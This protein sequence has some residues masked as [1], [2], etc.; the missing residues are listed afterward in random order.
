VSNVIRSVDPGSPAERAHISV[1]DILLSINGHEIRDVL[2]YKYYSYDAKLTI[3]LLS[4]GKKKRV[5]VRKPESADMGLEFETYLMD[6]ARSCANKCVF[7]FVDQLPR[8]MRDTLYFKDDDHRLSFLQGNYIT[9]TNLSEREIRRIIELKISPINISVHATEPELRAMLLGNKNGGRGIEIMR[10]FA[11]AGITMNCQIVCC[12]GLNDGEH[13][14]KSMADLA[15]MYPGVSSVSVVPVG[16]T[17]HREGLYPLCPFDE[18]LAA[19]TVAL[20][21]GFG[22]KC[23]AQYGTRMFFCADELYLKAHLPLPEDEYYEDY[24]QLENGVGMLRMLICEFRAALRDMPDEPDGN[25]F[26]I[27]CGRSAAPFMEMLINEAAEKYGNVRGVVHAVDNDFFGHTID[28]SGLVTGGDIVKQ[29]SGKE[30]GTRLLLPRNMLRHGEV[31]FLDDMTIDGL[32]EALGV[33]VR[34]VEQDGF[35]LA[36]AVFGS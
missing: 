11:A 18:K 34:V 35:D 3:E 29:L 19:E 31:V 12:P 7:C 27:A 16:L 9:L 4:E 32:S 36:D 23:L 2:D 5:T 20:V 1:G 24:P 28:V 25:P 33:P 26:S 14:A 10:E 22:E 8:G 15:D 6:K 13:L 17:K 30:L 21:D